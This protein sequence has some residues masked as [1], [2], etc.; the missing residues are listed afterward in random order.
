MSNQPEQARPESVAPDEREAVD[1]TRVGENVTA[2]LASAQEAADQMQA[3]ARVEAERIKSDAQEQAAAATV[4]ATSEATRIQRRSEKLRLEVEARRKEGQA[5]ADQ[6]AADTRA[7]AEAE[8]TRRLADADKRAQA[9]V[10]QA[11]QRAR[12]VSQEELRRQAALAAGAE[13]FEERLK[14]LLEVFRGMST[15]LED[16]V[17]TNQETKGEEADGEET[18]HAEGPVGGLEAALKPERHKHAPPT[19]PEGSLG[20]HEVDDDDA[21]RDR[22]EHDR[23][24]GERLPHSL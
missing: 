8:A 12:H 22:Q 23:D 19:E 11:E 6:Y 10:A 7:E 4:E 15:Q 3:S 20:R 2:V 24:Q 21:D 5:A 18:K 13:R 17:R 9:I 16:L 14:N 1:F